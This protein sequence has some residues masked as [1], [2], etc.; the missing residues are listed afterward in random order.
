M[1]RLLQIAIILISFPSMGFHIVGGEIE[2]ITIS[3]GLYRI[4]V[5]QYF[6]EAQAQNPGPEGTAEVYIFSGSTDEVISTHV[7]TLQEQELVRY[8]N[9][10][11]SIEELQTSRVLWSI[12]SLEL[13][14]QLYD[15]PEG[16]YIVWER[17]CRNST[18]VNIRNPNA[19][20]MK[21]VV[22]IPPLWKDGAPYIN[23]SP[24]LF[25]PLSD[26]ACVD[27]LY[28]TEFT[29]TDPDG[30][31]LVYSLTE[32]L[33]TVAQV[34][35]PIPQPKPHIVKEYAPGFEDIIPGSPSLNISRKGLLTVSPDE[36]GLYVFSVL[37][38]EYRNG[39]KIGQVQRDFQ[40]L[41]IDG[42]NPPDPPVVGIQVPGR[43]DFIPEVDTLKYD[44][45]DDKCFN[46]IVK[47]IAP[48]DTID[49][50]AE[51]VNFEGDITEI[52]EFQTAFIGANQD[53]LL[54]EVCAPGCPPLETK[55]FIVDLIAADDACPLPQLDTLTLTIQVEPPPNEFPAAT[56]SE[57]NVVLLEGT[58]GSV[59]IVG[60][61]QDDDIMDVSLMVEGIENAEN[62]GF[63]LEILSSEPG[64]VEA[65]LHWDTDC[66]VYDF[67]EIS[68]FN[69]G[70]LVDDAD[71]CDYENQD[72]LWIPHEVILPP[73]NPPEINIVG[74]SQN[75]L[76]VD[77]NDVVNKEIRAVD[78]DGDDLTLQLVENPFGQVEAE[79]K[80]TTGNTIVSSEF[81]WA[82]DCS[83]L[84]PDVTNT[85]TFQF[86]A[87]DFDKCKVVN[88]DTLELEII[89]DV[90]FNNPP[91]MEQYPSYELPVNQPFSLDIS[92]RDPDN[93]LI[94]L[95]FFS[96]SALPNSESLSFEPAEGLGEV[97]SQLSWTPECNLLRNGEPTLYDLVFVTFDEK[98][99][100]SKLDTAKISFLIRETRTLF[101]EFLPPN[102]F[103]PNNDGTND[104]FR[105]TDLTLKEQNLPT[106]NCQDFFQYVSIHDR[107]GK[108]VFYSDSREFEW[109]GGDLPSGTY[110]YLVKFSRSEYRSYIQLL[111]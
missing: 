84:E 45:I 17:C 54:V 10:E 111:R 44:L 68:R 23:S 90:P 52:F 12:D 5:I 3:P 69:V 86:V 101:E 102:A 97:S 81:K 93:D 20:G 35:L 76:E 87:E 43:D 19:T 14:P 66:E 15:D 27:Q 85:F 22:E 74:Q 98:C 105:L 49:L 13:D 42:C 103:S 30:D 38:E 32:P 58:E 106:D 61:D 70:I 82:I 94:Y 40:M 73:N 62:I 41:V 110:Y 108:Q 91:E 8:T 1:K 18:I 104:T 16:Y 63:S 77:L 50:R 46:F 31:S 4:N 59:T 107:T 99:P 24:I 9:E 37:V 26:Y 75:R 33:N 21:Y 2:F 28:Y 39:E 92:A 60:T 78:I 47:N 29:G 57:P 96:G 88:R 25:K 95:E 83:I 55:P 72:I 80:D 6:D 48:G 53:S 34:A 89:V 64:R 79:F 65:E 11:C 56:S 51:G 67:S 71:T 109:T 100:G 36:T 7:L